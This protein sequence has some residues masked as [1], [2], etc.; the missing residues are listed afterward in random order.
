MRVAIGLLGVV[1]IAGC[2]GGGSEP[3]E[4]PMVAAGPLSAG[5]AEGHL[6][7]PVGSPMGGYS[8][9]CGYLGSSSNQDTRDSNYTVN[10]DESTGVHT[11]PTIKAVWLDN[12][13]DHFVLIKADVIY[14]YDG[15][16]EALEVE[17]GDAIGADL[18]GRVVLATNHSHASFSNFSDQV[19]FYLGGDRYNEEAFQRFLSQASEIALEAF[20]TRETV[21]IGNSW[22]KDWDP[23]DLVYNDRRGDNDKLAVW[24][25]AEVGMGKDPYLHMLRID[26]LD[27]SP[28]AAV[29]TFGVHGTSLGDDSSMVSS[30]APGAIEHGFEATF[31]TP[32]VVMHLQGAGGDASPGG[33]DED[34]AKLES[35]GQFAAPLLYDAWEATPVGTADVRMETASRHIPEGL[36]AI[37]VT[38]DGTVDW[39]YL[40]FEEDRVPDDQIYDP[41]GSLISPLDEFNAP[42]GA[43]FCGSDDPL[44]PAGGIG[45]QVFPYSACMDVELVS[46]I[47]L[48]IFDL[49]DEEVPLPLP[50]STGAG[51]T[52]S[53][54]GPLTTLTETG[55]V[56]ERDLFMGFFPGETTAMYAEQ[57]RRRVKAELGYE[58]AL[59]VG[60]AQDH[61]G[62]L[63][64]PEDWLMGGY[65][66]NINIWGPLQ[67]EHIMEGMLAY[68]DA[69]LGTDEREPP[70]PFGLLAPTTYPDR[71]L[72]DLAPDATPA[73]GSLLTEAPDYFWMPRGLTRDTAEGI[74]G[75]LELVQDR[76]ERHVGIAQIA[77]QG[78][79]PAVDMPRVTLE[80]LDGDTWVVATDA[81]GRPVDSTGPEILIAT[82]P[83]PL[84]P[85][86]AE[87]EHRWVAL[88]QASTV[89]L[90]SGVVP[91]VGGPA[92]VD[93]PEVVVARLVVDGEHYTGGSDTWPWASEAYRVEGEPFT[94]TAAS[95][96]LEVGDGGLWVSLRASEAGW[97][98]LDLEGSSAGDNPVRGELT[99]LFDDGTDVIHEETLPGA[100]SEGR[101]W[102]EVATPKGATHVSVA[103]ELGNSGRSSLP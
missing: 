43:A 63:L 41:D 80:W 46:R 49:T 42:F 65:E 99:L 72:P 56:V 74:D 58:M 9:R 12:G 35:L 27:G 11:L 54:I 24:D 96:A 94:I 50:S 69:V 18:D 6:V 23:D 91:H 53:R 7:M 51:T 87:Q 101:T 39:S 89:P 55:E 38:R 15:L 30:D 95:L 103:D 62:Y 10:W 83:D 37:R 66:P 61:E 33:I 76:V 98:L 97:R 32:V 64:I 28:L 19:H 93:Q 40:P 100:V 2:G 60:Y 13:D 84:Y 29:F 34:Y 79:D 14:S 16:V 77:W 75:G 71:E 25:D 4:L 78:G 88:Y 1:G 86:D 70:A 8:S 59:M 20:D 31:D 68:G 21:A 92:D 5:A 57:W 67:A 73:A 47:L 22:H 17:L 36:E 85:A 90:V 82:T 26:R 48:G 44:I 3:G 81:S 102:V 45:S 52:A